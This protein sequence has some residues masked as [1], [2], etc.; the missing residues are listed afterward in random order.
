M[1]RAQKLKKG[2]KIIDPQDSNHSPKQHKT[3]T[4]LPQPRPESTMSH[5]PFEIP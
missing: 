5:S 3:N 2:A 1:Q 4:P